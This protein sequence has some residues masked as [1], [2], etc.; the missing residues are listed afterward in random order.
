M[1]EKK[2]SPLVD[3]LVY[4]AVRTLVCRLL[5]SAGYRVIEAGGGREALRLAAATV[6]EIAL[7]ITDVVM[8]GM[9]GRELVQQLSAARP[10]LRAIYVSGYTDDILANHGVLE[11]GTVLLSKPFTK[12]ALLRSVDEILQRPDAVAGPPAPST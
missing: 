6:D 8:P 4:A 12:A 3:W 7:L 1:S 11:P 9:N 2:K 10:R 5:V